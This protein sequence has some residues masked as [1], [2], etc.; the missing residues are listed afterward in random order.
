M[1]RILLPAGAAEAVSVA[2]LNIFIL[3]YQ[4]VM[5]LSTKPA[6]RRMQAVGENAMH[7]SG[8]GMRS[9]PGDKV[10][11]SKE[12]FVKDKFI[13]NLMVSVNLPNKPPAFLQ[14]AC[15]V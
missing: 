4:D 15:L 11:Q 12:P 3:L 2:D 14:E 7:G 8:A 10:P 6:L 1:F 5:G 9:L 13:P